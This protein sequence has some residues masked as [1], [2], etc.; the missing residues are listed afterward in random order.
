MITVY[1]A[2]SSR[3]VVSRILPVGHPVPEGV[4]WIDLHNPSAEEIAAVE[5]QF[6]LEVCAHSGFRLRG[7]KSRPAAGD[8]GVGR[9]GLRVRDAVAAQPRRA[10]TMPMRGRTAPAG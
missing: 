1:C 10:L 7:R 3:T 2:T 8:R 4:L 5:Q 6:G 9:A